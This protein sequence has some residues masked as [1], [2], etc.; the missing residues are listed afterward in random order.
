MGSAP[1]T[2][3]NY[4]SPVSAARILTAAR[5]NASPTPA[6]APA[7]LGSPA[8]F[9]SSLFVSNAPPAGGVTPRSQ[10]P[11]S[12][13]PPPKPLPLPEDPPRPSSRTS[14]TGGF[15]A[16]H[17]RS[18]SGPSGLQD[19]RPDSRVSHH[20]RTQSQPTNLTPRLQS[21]PL[22]T[23]SEAGPSMHYNS[24]WTPTPTQ[25]VLPLPPVGIAVSETSQKRFAAAQTPGPSQ[26]A[27]LLP[28]DHT[29]S[30]MASN[31]SLR[32]VGSYGKYNA[33][34]YLDPA[35]FPPEGGGN[36]S[37]A[38]LKTSS[39]V[40]RARSRAASVSSGLSYVTDPKVRG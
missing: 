36:G 14:S 12:P 10:Y 9:Q 16:G 38:P 39:P 21:Q 33:S 19:Q 32:S 17:S 31:Q 1:A 37:V 26:A 24:G 29:I 4:L 30:R 7:L 40:P 18:V 8:S 5:L 27:V 22:P 2:A 15:G 13:R 35:F 28:D 6:P 11:K 34:M 20:S 3:E 23:T 25:S